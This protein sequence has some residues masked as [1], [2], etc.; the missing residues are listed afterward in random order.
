MICISTHSPRL[1]LCL[2]LEPKYTPLPLL[3]LDLS[4]YQNRPPLCVESVLPFTFVRELNHEWLVVCISQN[5]LSNPICRMCLCSITQDF[6]VRSKFVDLGLPRWE[7]WWNSEW[8]F[9]PQPLH[10]DNSINLGLYG[11]KDDKGKITYFVPCLC[12]FLLIFKGVTLLTSFMFMIN[13]KG[14]ICANG[15]Y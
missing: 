8:L 15:L 13:C 1:T 7:V 11:V 4:V 5:I 9:R 14:G 2:L 10:L 3:V 6:L 12:N